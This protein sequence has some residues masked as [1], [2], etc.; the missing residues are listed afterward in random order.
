MQGNEC[1]VG[2]PV[3]LKPSAPRCGRIIYR[4]WSTL[5]TVLVVEPNALVAATIAKSF[6]PENIVLETH[7]P[8]MAARAIHAI[9][10]DVV[11]VSKEREYFPGYPALF[12]TMRAIAPGTRL[13]SM[14]ESGETSSTT[15]LDTGI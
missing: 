3:G 7:D 8:Y 1:Q 6:A 5:K 14:S 10:F 12:S 9:Q 13:L 4:L 11:I 15:A 2:Y